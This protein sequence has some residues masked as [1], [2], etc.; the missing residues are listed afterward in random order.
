MIVW[1]SN[2]AFS[3]F[4]PLILAVA[5]WAWQRRQITPSLQFSSIQLLRQVATTWRARLSFLPMLLKIAA[6]ALMIMAMA[7]PQR[8]DTKVKRNVEG[9][10]IML[11][12]DISDSMLIEDMQPDNRLESA[13]FHIRKFIEGRSSDRIGFIVFSGESY[14]RVPLTLDYQMLIKSVKDLKL[15][16][17]IKMGTA[18]GVALAN[19]VAR[20]KDSTARSRVI[21]LLTDGENNSGTIDPDT[22][23][24]IAKGYGI[25]V[26]SIGMGRDGQSQLPIYQ[27]D[28]FGNTV[29][30]YQPIHSTVN[31]AL[32]QRMAEQTGGK[33]YRAAEDTALKDVFV[34]INRLEKTKIDINQYTRYAELF[35][36][37]VAWAVFLYAL[38]FFLGVSILR[39]GP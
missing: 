33:F 16:R 23:I 13:K 15:S 32:L 19:A 24:D 39:R 37:Y 12:L 2:W 3:L 31:E 1:H 14:T 11:T 26:Y 38:G 29:K 21:I 20:I 7:R 6:I 18:I 9:I 35:S 34:D 8:A 27:T 30:R 4:V 10:D 5:W 25:K 28:A 22:A 17:T 36:S